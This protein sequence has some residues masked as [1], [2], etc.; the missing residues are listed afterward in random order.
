MLKTFLLASVAG[1]L[2]LVSV[3]AQARATDTDK[4]FL[5]Q[6]VQGGRYELELAKLGT[7]KATKPT[8]RHYAQMVAHD[9][10]QA[11]S[12]LT[13]L[14]KMESV[15]APSGMT[16]KDEAMLTK[17]KT[18]SGSNFNRAFVDEMNRINAEDK[19]S[20][21]QEKASTNESAI[22]SY[23]SRFAAMDAKHKKLAAELRS[24]VS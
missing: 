11:N 13:R 8:I 6:D 2:S 19:Q 18:M 16:S 1:S 4:S 9:H 23:T 10:V 22:K 14:A 3:A 24:A 20:A 21:D 17:L 7:T 12:A 15:N 5:T